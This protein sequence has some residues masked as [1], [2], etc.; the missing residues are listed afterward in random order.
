MKLK[1]KM[2]FPIEVHSRSSQQQQEEAAA[3]AA[4]GESAVEL[5]HEPAES[6][7][8]G[9]ASAHHQEVTVT[10]G[11]L[12]PA[13]I[14]QVLDAAGVDTGETYS[15]EVGTPRRRGHTRGVATL[16]CLRNLAK[17]I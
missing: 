10:G 1:Y 7:P 4:D 9:A 5:E 3:D 16:G 8:G 15:I 14:C 6:R 17:T 13:Q 11:Q 2:P 12:E